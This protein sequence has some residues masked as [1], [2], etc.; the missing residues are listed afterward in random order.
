MGTPTSDAIAVATSLDD[1]VAVMV[2]GP[3]DDEFEYVGGDTD[4]SAR[5][6]LDDP[7]ESVGADTYPG[8][9]RRGLADA[10]VEA[11]DQ[12]LLKRQLSAAR[13]EI[14]VLL[15]QL[16]DFGKVR[17]MALAHAHEVEALKARTVNLESESDQLRDDLADAR[18]RLAETETRARQ[19]R[20]AESQETRVDPAA[21]EAA[22]E[23][24][25]AVR[26]ERDG[27]AAELQRLAEGREA[28]E[29]RGARGEQA[30]AELAR[31]AET[32]RGLEAAVTDAKADLEASR[33][34]RAELEQRLDALE[35]ELGEAREGAE[36]GA[37]AETLEARAAELEGALSQAAERAQGAEAARDEAAERAERT[38]V[39]LERLRLAYVRAQEGE[40]RAQ[41]LEAEIEGLRAANEVAQQRVATLERSL[42]AEQARAAEA[43]E[44]GGS[45]RGAVAELEERLARLE[46]ELVRERKVSQ[47]MERR[48]EAAAEEAR[49][50]S[51]SVEAGGGARAKELE[52]EVQRLR[53]MVHSSSTQIQRYLLELEGAQ[54]AIARN[55][56]ETLRY[57]QRVT[58]LH[59]GINHLQRYLEDA[60]AAGEQ[61]V[62]LL[63][64]VKRCAGELR[65]LA[66]SSDRFG[67][68]MERAMERLGQILKDPAR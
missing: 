13:T 28:L 42:A 21:L 27:L 58:G 10:A 59:E 62:V 65:A 25:A 45:D 54:G 60:G 29:E 39:A 12:T 34:R 64:E 48:A 66:E 68:S 23:E 18:R 3:D 53:A 51:A 8:A 6:N 20:E 46:D 55:R 38:R 24:L 31:Q 26:A 56:Q 1:D 16:A 44:D 43:L 32:I 52:A 63:H 57:A 67:K 15:N 33:R 17:S 14:Q 50:Q 2:D 30:A 35:L 7:D 19:A 22:R 41:E 36:A 5:L 9:S 40:Q 47:E 4:P 61:A 49:K 37:R 11:H